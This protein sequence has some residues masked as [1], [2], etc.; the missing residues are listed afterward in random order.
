MTMQE[1][2]VR[3]AREQ[4]RQLLATVGAMPPDKLT[5]RPMDEGRCVLDLLA[6]CIHCHWRVA[7][8]LA[9]R[10]FADLPEAPDWQS[11]T[12]DELA[13]MLL[14]SVQDWADVVLSIPDAV[15][16]SEFDAPWGKILVADGLY[17]CYWNMAY[18]EGQ[19]NYIQTLYEDR[20]MHI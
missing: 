10:T 5:W 11:A 8:I 6:D 9:Q 4:A 15:L 7:K 3:R 2:I 14:S 18:H 20:E 16:V 1:L 19:I 17:H 12:L 13:H